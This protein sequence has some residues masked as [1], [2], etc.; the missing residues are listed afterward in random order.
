[1]TLLEREFSNVKA[2]DLRTVNICIACAKNAS[3]SISDAGF[4]EVTWS[5]VLTEV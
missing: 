5:F 3:S 4:A 1:M 2:D